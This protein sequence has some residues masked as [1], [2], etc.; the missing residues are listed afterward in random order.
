MKSAESKKNSMWAK[1]KPRPAAWWS[2]KVEEKSYLKKKAENPTA[3]NS[4]YDKVYNVKI[5]GYSIGLTFDAREAFSWVKHSPIRDKGVFFA[6]YA[7]PRV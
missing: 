7:V 5:A 4:A 6:K 2:K 3:G 1:G